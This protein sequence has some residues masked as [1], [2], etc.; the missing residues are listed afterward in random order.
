MFILG[1]SGEHE[2]LPV[3]EV[4][5]ILEGEGINYKIIK[6]KPL[7][8]IDAE[9][10]DPVVQRSALTKFVGKMIGSV[11]KI[12]NFYLDLENK[13]FSL[14][15]LN[16]S[17]EKLDR[18]KMERL[19][20]SKV[21]GKVNLTNPEIKLLLLKLDKIYITELLDRPDLGFKYRINQVRPFRTNLSLQP[22][23]ARLL[24]NLARVKKN[25]R[26]IDPFCGS[27]S[28]LIESYLMGMKPFG[29]DSSEKMVEGCKKNLNYYKINAEILLG[30]FSKMN[31]FGPFDAIATD[32]PYGRGSTTNRENVE[33]L[34]RRAFKV[35]R[36][37]IKE[38]GYI[39]IILPSKEY[40]KL[41][42]EFFNVLEVHEMKVHRSL[43]RFFT[44]LR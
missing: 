38:N 3:S 34:Y 44:V 12:E 43:T 15:F 31:E 2:T 39:S 19:A 6:E 27:G 21:K 33:N 8:F 18:M 14:R 41:A 5:G 22:K 20:G 4:K 30:D 28:V 17:E 36:E 26:I 29:I 37:N 24:V 25:D 42:C 16:F 9:S 10:I 35:F 7:L 13:T 23:M 40:V 32:P 1:L 11:D